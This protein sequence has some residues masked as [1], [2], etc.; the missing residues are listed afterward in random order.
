MTRARAGYTLIEVMTAVVVMTIGATGILAMQGASV[1]ANEDASE[2]S[3][4]LNFGATWLERIKRD[5]RLWIDTGNTALR[6]APTRYLVTVNTNPGAYFVP[7]STAN[8]SPGADHYGFDTTAPAQIRYCVNLRLTVVH[9]YN[10]LTQGADVTTDAN[11]LRADLRIWW[12]RRSEDANRASP[13]CLDAALTDSQ[14]QLNRLRKHYL[15]T[16]VNWRAPGWP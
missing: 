13:A 4:A 8:E 14:A 5:A 7:T 9:A 2:T 1:R 3:V 6:T 12:H 15:S 10:P 11:A 16:V